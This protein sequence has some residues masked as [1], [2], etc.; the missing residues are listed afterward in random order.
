MADTADAPDQSQRESSLLSMTKKGTNKKATL[1]TWMNF[2]SIPD[3]TY[4]S[5]SIL[6]FLE[7]ALEPIPIINK[8]QSSHVRSS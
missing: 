6:E 4:I 7:Q 8:P 2:H 1:T 3:E 5:P